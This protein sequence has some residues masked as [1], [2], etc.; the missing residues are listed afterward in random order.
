MADLVEVFDVCSAV[1]LFVEVDEF[2]DAEAWN[3]GWEGFGHF[4]HAGDFEGFFFGEFVGFY[5]DALCKKS[6]CFRY[7]FMERF[8]VELFEAEIEADFVGFKLVARDKGARAVAQQRSEQVG[9]SVASHEFVPAIPVKDAVNLVTLFQAGTVDFMA[10]FAREFPHVNN[11]ENFG[12]TNNLARV[13]GLTAT[14]RI[15][16]RLIQSD[17][18]IIFDPIDDGLTLFEVTV[19]Q[20]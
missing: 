2:Y 4:N 16:N 11:P 20:V 1:G 9:S 10:D 18:L 19:L 13:A 6:V 7:I 8:R 3:V 12:S 5:G 17:I 15:E 14:L